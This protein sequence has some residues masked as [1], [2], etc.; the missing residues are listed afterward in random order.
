MTDP[1]SSRSPPALRTSEEIEVAQFVA[2]WTRPTSPATSRATP[3]LAQQQQHQPLHR[4]PPAAPQRDPFADRLHLEE[5]QQGLEREARRH[6]ERLHLVEEAIHALALP[7]K[8]PEPQVIVREAPAPPPLPQPEPLQLYEA[9]IEALSSSTR[10]F[11]PRDRNEV[12]C[13]VTTLEAL[14]ADDKVRASLS[15]LTRL[16]TLLLAR[17]TSWKYAVQVERYEESRRIG[18][19]A[20]PPRPPDAP[21]YGATSQGRPR[22]FFNQRGGGP[23]RS[24]RARGRGATR[25]G[26]QA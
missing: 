13:L 23:N 22:R 3:P 18:L 21:S 11:L 1:P 2:N 20:Q 26:P 25:G 14:L 19:F 4:P 15:V 8:P 9:A 5:V 17:A 12:T 24:M 6:E 7:P 16:Q 10:P